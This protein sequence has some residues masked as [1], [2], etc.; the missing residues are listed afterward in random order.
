MK[1]IY[2]IITILIIAIVLF[3]I[4]GYTF[5]FQKNKNTESTP[6]NTEILVFKISME[7]YEYKVNEIINI[8]VKI[9]NNGNESINLSYPD[10]IFIQKVLDFEIKTPEG[11]ILFYKGNYV[12]M[13]PS[14]IEILPKK[15]FINN[16]TIVGSSD[17]WF[18]NDNIST[19]NFTTIGEYSI[20]G[21]YKSNSSTTMSA[22]NSKNF[23]N[24]ILYSNILTFRIK[25]E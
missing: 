11:Y 9:K 6:N 12:L 21:I 16:I 4:F 1:R 2:K 7:K 8:T 18:G 19:Y 24:G 10:F 13:P 14:A 17:V 3:A 5:Y 22:T 20:K 25:E 23:W 15:E